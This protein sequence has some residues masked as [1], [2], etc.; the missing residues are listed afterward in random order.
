M[1][2]NPP[3]TRP[4]LSAHVGNVALVACRAGARLPVP[5]K[6]DMA[7]AAVREQVVDRSLTIYDGALVVARREHYIWSTF[8]GDE[9]CAPGRSAATPSLS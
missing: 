6:G 1:L 5:W 7:E 9:R 3:E 2:N 4:V 8:A